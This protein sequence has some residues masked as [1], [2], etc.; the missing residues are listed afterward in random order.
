MS[1]EA[2]EV[3]L[4]TMVFS[5]HKNLSRNGVN[6]YKY[7]YWLQNYNKFSHAHAHVIATTFENR[8]ST[9]KDGCFYRSL[10]FLFSGHSLAEFS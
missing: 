10:R 3:L 9:I 8:Y 4:F 6:I 7:S 1:V 2:E 5:A